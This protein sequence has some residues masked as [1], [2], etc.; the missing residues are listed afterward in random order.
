MTL[1]PYGMTHVTFPLLHGVQT[2][3]RVKS[4]VIFSIQ[5]CWTNSAMSDHQPG[6]IDRLLPEI[7]TKSI[8]KSVEFGDSSER[9]SDSDSDDWSFWCAA[10]SIGQDLIGQ[11]S[12]G[13]MRGCIGAYGQLI[14]WSWNSLSLR[15]L[16]L[17]L[18]LCS[19]AAADKH[20]TSAGY[21]WLAA[22]FRHVQCRVRVSLVE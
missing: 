14:R 3:K 10:A 22:G 19:P 20:V 13:D 2:R 6:G 16:S 15:K 4:R 9:I 12:E 18:F 21:T 17:L 1:W 5:Y 8:W 7:V 11:D